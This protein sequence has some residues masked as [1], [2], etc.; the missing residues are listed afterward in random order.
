MAVEE[1]AT[2]E[3]LLPLG[4]TKE[5]VPIRLEAYQA[6]RKERG[7]YVNTESVAQAKIPEK[8]GTYLR[9]E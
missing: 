6:L 5:D 8:R 4:T 3:C 2:L 7:E 9:C 1:A